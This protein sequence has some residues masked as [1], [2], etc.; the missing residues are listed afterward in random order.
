M[1]RESWRV[2]RDSAGARMTFSRRLAVSVLLTVAAPG[3]VQA[4]TELS[5]RVVSDSGKPIAGATVTLTSVRYSVTTDSLGRFRL[6]GTSGSTLDLTLKAAGFRDAAASVVLSRGRSTVR[7]FV[8][9]SDAAPLPEVNPSDRVLRGRVTSTDGEPVS[10]ANVQLNGGRR[11]VA[12]DS[13]RFTI[14]VNI[15]RQSTLLF[16]RIGFEPAEV[17]LSEMPDTAI[18]VLMTAVA[19]TLSGQ[20]ITGRAP[21]ARLE[22]GGFYQRM[23][24]VEKGARVGWFVTPEELEQ[25]RPQN[26]TDAVR[27]FPN[28]R[29]SPID[30]GKVVIVGG[31]PMTWSDGTPL[32]RKFRIEDTDGCPLTVFLDRLR[33]Q[34]SVVGLEKVDEEINTI[35]Q[36]HAVAGIEVYPR[37][38]GAPPGYVAAGGTCGVVLIWTK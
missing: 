16:R 11:H 1:T 14:P 13:G 5:G 27:H 24:E 18:R 22:H 28:I 26:V 4:Q 9:V 2:T 8:M 36:P 34:P 29:L 17:K 19:R 12:D 33:I 3:A 32:A 10:Y 21:Y 7:D 15:S 6:T 25:R 20:V 30:D 23:A 38:T 35:V 31:L 37:V